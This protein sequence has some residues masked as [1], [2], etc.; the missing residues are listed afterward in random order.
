MS[1]ADDQ[2]RN[3]TYNA[4]DELAKR[5]NRVHSK[6]PLKAAE[7]AFDFENDIEKAKIKEPPF[8]SGKTV[9]DPE[10]VLRGIQKDMTR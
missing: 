8:G 5:V 2:I 6:N 1:L 4:L 7:A 3:N 9:M 10:E